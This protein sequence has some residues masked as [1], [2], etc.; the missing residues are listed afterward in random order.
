MSRLK[1]AIARFF[2]PNG[3]LSRKRVAVAIG[4]SFVRTLGYTVHAL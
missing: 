1:N 3:K 4:A 2:R